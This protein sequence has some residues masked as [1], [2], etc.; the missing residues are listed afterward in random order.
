MYRDII[1][2]ELNEGVDEAYLKEVAQDILEKWMAHQPGFIS[3]EMHKNKTGHYTDI[4]SWD[5]ETDAKKAE[6]SMAQLPDAA[7]WFA[8]YK[9]DSIRSENI[10]RLTIFTV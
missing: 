9:E 5:S 6:L 2:Y 8:C 7:K 1:H 10:D 3:W 4:V